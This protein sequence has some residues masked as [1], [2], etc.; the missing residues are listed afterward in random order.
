MNHPIKFRQTYTLVTLFLLVGFEPILPAFAQSPT[1]P[2]GQATPAPGLTGPLLPADG[3]RPAGVD[4]AYILG[5]GDAIEITVFGY[6]EYTGEKVIL[7]DGTI[8]LSLLGAVPA[9]KMTTDQLEQELTNRL[10]SFLVDPVVS[11][12]LVTLRPVV[13]NVAGEVMRPGPLQLEDGTTLSAAIVQAGG[14]T[15]DADIREVTLRR[16]EP[17]GESSPIKIDLWEAISSDNPPPDPILQP[18]DS[19]YVARLSANAT[20]DRRRVAT[21]SLAPETVRVRVVGEVNEP[22]EIQIPPNSSVS[23]AVAIAGGPTNDAKLSR[24]AYIRLNDE[25]QVERQVV[26]L[27]NLTDNYQIQEGDVIFVPED[28]GSV[29]L[30]LA[31]RVLGPFGSF[32]NIF[33]TLDRLI[34]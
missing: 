20:L 11:V 21:S 14:V 10:Q 19:I 25:G 4:S 27:R 33:S 7:P 1:A 23:S 18:G 8:T 17:N 16:Y 15:R 30:D 5:P 12:S 32:L 24:V 13:I 3:E 26:D 22:G 29:L 6:E 34:Q 9:A 28:E 31:G 2:Q